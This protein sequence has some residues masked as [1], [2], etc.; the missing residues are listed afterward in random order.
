[1][2]PFRLFLVLSAFLAV[3]GATHA[4]TPGLTALM[5][6]HLFG[7]ETAPARPAPSVLPWAPPAGANSFSISPFALALN[8]RNFDVADRAAAEESEP[9][10]PVRQLDSE[11]ERAWLTE[12]IHDSL[13][14]YQQLFAM[15]RL[16]QEAEQAQPAQPAQDDG[17]NVI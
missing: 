17:R 15:E 7:P 10:T 5:L 13:E 1:M 3:A 12:M 4:T 14:L 16:R 8:E 9:V 2:K 6:P 11:C